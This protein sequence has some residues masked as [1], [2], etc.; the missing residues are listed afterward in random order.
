M[1]D[2]ILLDP[3]DLQRKARENYRLYHK[4]IREWLRLPKTNDEER[5]VALALLGI[6]GHAERILWSDIPARYKASRALASHMAQHQA[7]SPATRTYYFMTFIDDI[8]M[9]SDRVP[10]LAIEPI[11]QKVRRAVSSLKVHSIVMLEVHPL[12]NYPGGQAGRSL[13]LHAHAIAWTDEP[14]DH[15]RAEAAFNASPAWTCSLGAKPVDIRPIDRA[16]GHM[17]RVA[18]YLAKQVPSVKNL[19]PS[20]SK[21]GRFIMLDT[22][23]GYR[24]GLACRIFEGQSQVELMS[25]MFGVG[26]GR[27]VRQAV[28]AELTRWHAA[29]SS[30]VL[31]PKTFDVWAFWLAIRQRDVRS[32]YRPYRFV[33]GAYAPIAIVT[34]PEA[35]SNPAIESSRLAAVL[36]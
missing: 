30:D 19:M 2:K 15:G 6:H 34:P 5:S 12:M 24:N 29:R 18:H 22:T 1:S 8:G 20:H 33:G 21:P 23:R 13:L 35:A 9:T 36:G 32:M 3:A 31:V 14:F 7:T 10:N 28:R 17:E 11:I 4:K 16:P 25:V 27:V 26:D